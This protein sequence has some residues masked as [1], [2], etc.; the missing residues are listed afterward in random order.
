M[1][2]L[3]VKVNDTIFD[4]VIAFFNKLPQKDVKLSFE[5]NDKLQTPKKLHSLSIKTKG[6]KFNR[7]EANER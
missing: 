5:D 6:Y 1:R 4:K 7:A 3:K 2:T